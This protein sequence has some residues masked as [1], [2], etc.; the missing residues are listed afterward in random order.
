MNL[1]FKSLS[2]T[3]L[4]SLLFSFNATLSTQSVQL[5]SDSDFLEILVLD[6]SVTKGKAVDEFS[7][8]RVFRPIR[9]FKKKVSFWLLLL[10]SG[11]AICFLFITLIDRSNGGLDGFLYDVSMVFGGL[12]LGSL[13][14][15]V[16]ILLALPAIILVRIIEELNWG[17]RFSKCSNF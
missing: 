17:K 16:F 14:I 11:S 15:I 7:W 1:N 3:L 4:L 12:L 5:F 9:V 8:K 13:T 10:C 6:Q 2:I